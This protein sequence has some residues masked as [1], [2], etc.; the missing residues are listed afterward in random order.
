MEEGPPERV[1]KRRGEKGRAG[2]GGE[3]REE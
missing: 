1:S 2:R 3:G